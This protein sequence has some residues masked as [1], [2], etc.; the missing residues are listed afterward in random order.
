M[1]FL[2]TLWWAL[3]G[4]VPQLNSGNSRMLFE[5]CMGNGA[6][7]AARS[8]YAD[9]KSPYFRELHNCPSMLVET[10]T[11]S[12][13]KFRLSASYF[14]TDRRQWSPIFSTAAICCRV[15]IGPES[16]GSN[17]A[18]G[19]VKKSSWVLKQKLG[20]IILFRLEKMKLDFDL[21]VT[22]VF[23]RDIFWTNSG[24]MLG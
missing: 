10:I 7:R 18:T 16:T 20:D 15:I 8:F 9:L 21:L 17:N 14:L 23:K 24:T 1:F 19:F 13:L 2:P 11:S 12:I 6:P 4:S 5:S 22:Q 3:P